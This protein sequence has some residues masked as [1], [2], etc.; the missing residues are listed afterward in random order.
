MS[1]YPEV[2]AAPGLRNLTD[3]ERRAIAAL[4]RLAKRWPRSLTLVSMDGGLQVVL[5]KEY[6]DGNGQE[7]LPG[8]ER[9]ELCVV[10]HISGI[11]NDGGGW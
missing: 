11:P 6:H 2:D 3:D 7:F 8:N 9:Q 10:A 5:T 1:D 4:E